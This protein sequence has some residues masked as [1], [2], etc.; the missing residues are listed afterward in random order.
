MPIIYYT[1]GRVETASRTAG[2]SAVA[3]QPTNGSSALLPALVFALSP[4]PAPNL[5]ITK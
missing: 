2:Y 4:S 1:G 5:A 3:S